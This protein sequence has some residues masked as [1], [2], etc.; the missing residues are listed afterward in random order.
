MKISVTLSAPPTRR[1]SSIA[2]RIS[3]ASRPTPSTDAGG[4]KPCAG[5]SPRSVNAAVMRAPTANAVH[6][7]SD[8]ALAT[9][10][11]TRLL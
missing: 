4:M 8:N 6:G 9:A 11:A 1:L 3:A 7:A 10:S 5:V 2:T